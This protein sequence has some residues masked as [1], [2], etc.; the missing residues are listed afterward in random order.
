MPD[1]IPPEFAQKLLRTIEDPNDYG[2]HLLFNDF[3]SH[4]PDD[5][6]AK[7]AADCERDEALAAFIA[8]EYY[9]EPVTVKRLAGCAAGTLGH[10]LH[11]FITVNGLEEKLA[12]NY[13]AFHEALAQNGLLDRMPVQ[14]HYAVIRGFQLHDFLHV[15]TGYGPSPRDEIALQAFCL[16][17]MRFPYF[18]IFTR[19]APLAAA[20]DC[21]GVL[22]QMVSTM[23]AS[24]LTSGKP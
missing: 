4:A 14:L 18:A 2:V 11:G 16:A 15:V 17:Q 13:K 8:D 10:A 5:V 23:S 3:W 24:S 12:T 6:I 22:R 7:Y 9:G 21:A 19:C 20:N 1:R